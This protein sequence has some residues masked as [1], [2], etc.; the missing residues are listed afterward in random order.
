MVRHGGPGHRHQYSPQNSPAWRAFVDGGYSAEAYIK[1]LGGDDPRVEAAWAPSLLH[2][3]EWGPTWDTPG[4]G[5]PT[6][7]QPTTVDNSISEQD[8]PVQIPIAPYAAVV[9]KESSVTDGLVEVSID[10]GLASVHDLDGAD[11]V[12]FTDQIFCI[13]KA[14]DKTV[15]CPSKPGKK[16]PEKPPEAI[17]PIPLTVPFYVAAGGSNQAGT[18][19]MENMSV[20]DDP[21]TPTQLPNSD[22]LCPGSGFSEGDPHIQTFNGGSYDFQ[23]AGEYT[24]VRSA[25]GDV[26]V[27]VRATPA[28]GSTTVAW[29]TAVAMRVISTNVEVDVGEPPAVLVDGKRI[30]L[31]KYK[32]GRSL[33]GGGRLA[34][35]SNGAGSDVVVTWPDGG[36]LDVFS[37]TLAENAAFTPPP[38]GVESFSG[39]L[40]AVVI[41]S[42]VQTTAN[43]SSETLL[44]GDGHSYVVD[45]LTRVGFKALY[46]PFADSWRVTTKTSLFTYPKGKSTGSFDVKGFPTR[47]A[48]LATLPVAKRKT[49]EANCKAAGVTDPKLLADCELDVGETGQRALATTTAR[50]QS[51]VSSVTTTT[52]TPPAVSGHPAS[53][54][55]NHACSAVSTAEV[56]QAVGA[57]DSQSLSQP[58]DCT[59]RPLSKTEEDS[60]TFSHQSAGLFESQHGGQSG[61]GPVPSLGHSAYCIVNPMFLPDQSYVVA[62]LGAA[63]SLQVL[64]GN[65]TQGTMLVKDSLL[66]ISG[67]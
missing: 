21:S 63:G 53:Y 49:A 43:M 37:D 39:L 20:P 28:E 40:S 14:C 65:C 18:L 51:R 35:K 7:L 34:Y 1:A 36:Q 8:V 38:A 5:V 12:G 57:V 27:Q 56:Q 4:V 25:N 46:G 11:Q 17:K 50:V 66:H 9:D 22:G 67:L 62:S 13:G 41:P 44:G 32:G 58:G 33:E 2:T 59:F 3:K 42:G 31:S 16:A 23:G 55:F 6:G 45:P 19:T 10:N 47:F 61:S 48:T 54:Y 15:T 26:D 29:N 60:V 24:L 52:T 30:T 64:A